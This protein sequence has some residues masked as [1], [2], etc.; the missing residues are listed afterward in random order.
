MGFLSRLKERLESERELELPLS[1]YGKLPIYKD[2]LRTGLTG[3]E[4]QSVRQWLDRGISH[5][6]A[7]R[8]EYREQ[9]I[10]E[11]ALLLRFNGAQRAVLAV[12]WGSHDQGMLRRFPFLCF[13]SV[14]MPRSPVP[15]LAAVDLLAQI[16]D[17]ARRWRQEL[18][19]LAS[20]EAFYRWSRGRQLSLTE[21]PERVVRQE[22]Y[23]RFGELTVGDYARA[24]YGD[25][26]SLAAWA[27]L[28]RTVQRQ[29][30]GDRLAVRLPSC[31][32]GSILDQ[33]K[34]WCALLSDQ[35][36]KGPGWSV[37][38]PLYDERSGVVVLQRQ[39]RDD[40]VLVLHPEMPSYEFIEDLRPQQVATDGVDAS[41]VPAGRPLLPTVGN[42]A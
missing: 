10:Y 14:P 17:Q 11:H 24:L 19:Q 37:I 20:A 28:Q 4:A 26:A 25:D 42:T 36:A 16:V 12:L 41:S 27:T 2:F 8:P 22:L 18:D 9:T 1:T 34:L 38:V 40:D 23:D 15:T 33:A 21:R 39:L 13:T 29:V 6:W 3:K 7:S 30:A 5:Y 32:R 35:V 31:A